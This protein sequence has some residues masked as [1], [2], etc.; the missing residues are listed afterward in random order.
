MFAKE[1]SGVLKLGENQHG[2]HVCAA[3]R[4]ATFDKQRSP[5]TDTLHFSV[6]S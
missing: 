2:S 6:I 1:E 3:K 5:V 4:V